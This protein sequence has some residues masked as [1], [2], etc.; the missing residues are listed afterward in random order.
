MWR[1]SSWAIKRCRRQIRVPYFSEIVATS[2]VGKRRSYPLYRRSSMGK[3]NPP[4]LPLA[5][6][7][8]TATRTWFFWHVGESRA[9]R[10]G[11]Q[12]IL[13]QHALAQLAGADVRD[14]HAEPLRRRRRSPPPP[15]AG[16]RLAGVSLAAPPLPGLPPMPGVNIDGATWLSPVWSALPAFFW[17]LGPGAPPA[18][19]CRF[20]RSGIRTCAA[21]MWAKKCLYCI[22]PSLL[23]S[24][25]DD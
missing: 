15:L 4:L 7:H 11:R 6:T 8:P 20:L 17:R 18:P 5:L 23:S 16:P 12:K 2:V 9:Q 3:W 22:K 21:R 14:A 1:P 13:P 19:P 24:P 25:R 10:P